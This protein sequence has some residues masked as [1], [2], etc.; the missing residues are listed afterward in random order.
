MHRTQNLTG[1][2]AETD[3]FTLVTP[4][5]I[6]RGAS[7]YLV[8]H[9]WNRGVYYGGAEDNPFPPADAIGA[10][11]MAAYGNREHLYSSTAPAD[12]TRLFRRAVDYFCDYLGRHEPVHRATGDEDIDL[13]LELSPFLWNDDPQRHGLHVVLALKA[14][15]KDWDRTHGGAR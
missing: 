3:G 5:D 9:G 1:T 15:A 12:E 8:Q 14:A 2:A 11:S 10:I 7:E 4:A 6:L 13:D